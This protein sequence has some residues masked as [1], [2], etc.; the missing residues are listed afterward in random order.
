MDALRLEAMDA[1]VDPSARPFVPE[2]GFSSCFTSLQRRQN[3][4]RK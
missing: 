2:A 4:C 3:S 1:I